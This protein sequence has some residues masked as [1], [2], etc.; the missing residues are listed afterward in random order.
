MSNSASYNKHN[1]GTTQIGLHSVR[2]ML[3][4]EMQ[5]SLFS[6]YTIESLSSSSGVKLVG[7]IDRFGIDLTDVQSKIMEG[8]LR[9]FTETNYRGNIEPRDTAQIAAEKYSEGGLPPTYKYVKEVPRLRATQAQIMDWA[10]VNKNSISEKERAVEALNHLGTTQYC[11]Y[12]DRLAYGQDGIPEKDRSGRWKK[13]EVM[14]VDTLFTIKEVRE[15]QGGSLKYYEIEI[16]PIFLDQRESYF[17]LIPYNWRE[18]VRAIV[19][20]KK[21]S[22]YTFRFLMFLRY[23]YEMKRRSP[24]LKP[25]FSLKWAWE[26]IAVAIKMPE[27]VYKRQKVRANKILEDAYSVAKQLGYLNEYQR[28]ENSDTLV[29]N[30]EKYYPRSETVILPP[31]A[32]NVF[33]VDAER[34][35]EFFHAEKTKVDKAHKTPVGVTKKDHLQEFENLIQTRSVEEAFKVIKWGLNTKYWCTRLGTPAKLRSFFS[36]AVSEMKNGSSSAQNEEERIAENKKFAQAVS[37]KIEK[38][39]SKSKVDVL[40]TYVEIGNGTH[41]P[42]CIAYKEKGFK[43]QF[44]N[45]L[46]KWDILKFISGSKNG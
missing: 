20:S 39:Q 33:S 42:T 29:F 1:E 18:E 19:G 45:A 26:E 34:L 22:S 37:Y 4:S 9:G 27:S 44:E 40:S 21:A 25:P 43:E 6:D 5:L 11:F 7:K 24:K 14:A 41:Q 46:R 38:V 15:E 32:E 12:Y 2:N 3:G 35:F 13:E 36:E 8:I 30:T 17:M 23:Q 10:G 31:K 16:S 28:C